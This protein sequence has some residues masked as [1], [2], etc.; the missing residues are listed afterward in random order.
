MNCP[1]C[2]KVLSITK[3]LMP[4]EDATVCKYCYAVVPAENI[5]WDDGKFHFN[6][7]GRNANPKISP[8]ILMADQVARELDLPRIHRKALSIIH[9]QPNLRAICS[10]FFIRD[11]MIEVQIIQ[12]QDEEE[13]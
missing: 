7:I 1:T 10:E 9:A 6:N 4:S 3:S 5:T 12:E 11:D 2:G 8:R 13:E